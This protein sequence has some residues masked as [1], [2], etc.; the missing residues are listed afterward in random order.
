MKYMMCKA[1]LQQISGFFQ[2]QVIM[3]HIFQLILCNLEQSVALLLLQ[4]LDGKG[5]HL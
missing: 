2:L 5:D 1:D 4:I 3:L